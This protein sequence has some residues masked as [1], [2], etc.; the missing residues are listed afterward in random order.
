MRSRICQNIKKF[1]PRRPP[2]KDPTTARI[3]STFWVA[4]ALRL[5]HHLPD[6]PDAVLV[7]TSIPHDGRRFHMAV[8]DGINDALALRGADV[9]ISVETGTNIAKDASD[10]ILLEKSLQIITTAILRSRMEVL[11]R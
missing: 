5:D 1:I 10:I 3:H 8:A 2:F 7:V 11:A 6:S 4:L 9:G